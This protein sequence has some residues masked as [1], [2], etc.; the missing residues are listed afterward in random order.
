MTKTST[1][2]I[3][4]KATAG[5]TPTPAKSNKANAKTKAQNKPSARPK[6]TLKADTPSPRGKDKATAPK[7]VTKHA[8]LIALLE[9]EDGADIA[10]LSKALSWQA[11]T[12]RAALSRLKSAG[13]TLDKYS[14]GKPLRTVYRIEGAPD[15]KTTASKPLPPGATDTSTG[16]PA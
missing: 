13:Y 11:H 15:Q 16:E 2:T 9:R 10:A 8:Q 4:R 6:A 12:V 5:N 14:G 3:S 7:R 1:K